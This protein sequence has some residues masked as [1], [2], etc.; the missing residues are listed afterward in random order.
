MNT[1]K[2]TQ[3][4]FFNTLFDQDEHTVFCRAQFKEKKA[5]DVNDHVLHASQAYIGFTINP[6]IKGRSRGQNNVKKIRTFLFENDD[7]SL[8]EQEAKVRESGLPYTACVFS[9]NKSL[10]YFIT[11]KDALEDKVEYDAIW[12]AIAKVLE[13]HNYKADAAVCDTARFGRLPNAKRHQTGKIQTLAKLNGRVSLE[14]LEHWL[15]QNGVDWT[16]YLPKTSTSN[17]P[18]SISLADLDE[19]AEWIKKYFLKNEQYVQGNK[20][21]YQYKYT[22]FLKRAGV[23]Q[24]HEIKLILQKDSD[25][26]GIIDKR[27]DITKILNSDKGDE[28]IYVP[29]KEERRQYMLDQERL[30]VEREG[31]QRRAMLKIETEA[32]TTPKT[33][34]TRPSRRQFFRDILNYIHVNNDIYRKDYVDPD[35]LNPTIISKG[36]FKG[37]F[38]FFDEDYVD[39]PEYDGFIN[40]PSI[41]N[42]QQTIDSKWNTFGRVR[43]NIEKGEWPTIK[44][45]LLHHFGETEY[46]HDQYEEILDWLT[47]LILFPEIRQQAIVLYSKDQGTAKSAFA[48]LLELLVGESN[49]S[50]IK[51]NELESDFNQLWVSSLVLNLDEPMFENKKKMTKVIREMITAKKQNLRKMREEYTK[52]NFYAKVVVTTNDTDFIKF[53]QADRRYWVRRS[54]VIKAADEDADF[55]EKLAKEVGHFIYFLQYERE[56]KYPEKADATFWLPK[57]ITYT[58]SFKDVCVDSEDQLPTAI[59]HIFEDWFLNEKNRNSMQVHFLISDIIVELQR[60]IQS[61]EITGINLNKITT[62]DIGKVLRNELACTPPTKTTRPKVDEAVFSGKSAPGRWYIAHRDRLKINVDQML[63]GV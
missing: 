46:D 34:Q 3:Q 55:D 30:R 16:D 47:V 62:N 48:Y 58:N 29:S 33:T 56:L 24:E 19:K 50:K 5:S 40:V 61:N 39:L 6:I 26:R 25:I 12:N 1:E 36:T 10:H 54:P 43:H 27:L 20:Y 38:G 63:F 17:M 13:T 28:A 4:Q 42:Y 23:T 2:P 41:L 18:T 14:T 57:S 44:K 59:R 15:T 7:L 51:D 49:F 37:K 60:K 52:V 21:M 32:A 11:L 22:R 8:E 53:E 31:D 9:G 35:K 45:L